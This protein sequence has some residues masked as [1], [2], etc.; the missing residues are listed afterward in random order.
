MHI[1]FLNFGCV[2][3]TFSPGVNPVVK[4]PIG[5]CVT[6]NC[7]CASCRGLPVALHIVKLVPI[8]IDR[9]CLVC[10][11]QLFPV[12]NANPITQI[13]PRSLGGRWIFFYAASE[14]TK[15]AK[16]V[17]RSFISGTK[18]GK[19]VELSRPDSCDLCDSGVTEMPHR[20]TESYSNL[21]RFSYFDLHQVCK[22]ITRSLPIYEW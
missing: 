21:A 19:K 13:P 22:I 16:S 20:R 17:I 11:L 4:L 2:E 18:T 8:V 12:G 3:I 5:Q 1:I 7:N 15:E 14:K 9:K 10:Q 6:L